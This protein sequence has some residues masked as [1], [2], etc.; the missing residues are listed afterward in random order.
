MET[1]LVLIKP[2]AV[3][4]GLVSE[5]LGRFDP[6]GPNGPRLVDVH[7]VR[8]GNMAEHQCPE[9]ITR[10]RTAVRTARRIEATPP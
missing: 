10:A 2:D 6:N 1:T 3:R 4:R 9:R 7:P 5:I 8:P